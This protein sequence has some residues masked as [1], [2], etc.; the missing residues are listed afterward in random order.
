MQSSVTGQELTL[1]EQAGLCNPLT[2][3]PWVNLPWGVAAASQRPRTADEP[4]A[5]V[6]QGRE[7][8]RSCLLLAPS[9]ESCSSAT[10]A[11]RSI[12]A[13][14]SSEQ[15]QHNIGGE[16]YTDPRLLVAASCS[17]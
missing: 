16:N 17:D 10:A 5:T 8:W 15:G 12:L 6:T 1:S 9:L 2:R 7:G 4:M 3:G 11:G 13:G 14:L